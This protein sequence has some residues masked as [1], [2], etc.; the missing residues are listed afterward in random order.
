MKRSDFRRKQL[1]YLEHTSVTPPS[2]D[3]VTSYLNELDPN[4]LHLSRYSTILPVERRILLKVKDVDKNEPLA[5][6]L[7]RYYIISDDISPEKKFLKYLIL[8]HKGLV[9]MEDQEFFFQVKQANKGG[10]SP[11][12][13]AREAGIE[14]GSG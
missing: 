13:Q 11:S 6:K 1:A 8:E 4:R 2:D 5:E 7:R 3:L 10:K 12:E 9:E 14:R